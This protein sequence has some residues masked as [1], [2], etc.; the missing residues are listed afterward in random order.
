MYSSAEKCAQNVIIHWAVRRRRVLAIV[1]VVAALVPTA[2]AY[3]G[4]GVNRY[5]AFGV[6]GDGTIAAATPSAPA[7]AITYN[8][9]LAPVG[10][11]LTAN[12]TPSGDS[13]TADLSVSGLAP[14]RG[15]SVIA[16]VNTCGGV[17]GGEG[18]RFQKHIDPAATPG[19]PSANP[20]YSNP[21]NE[22]WL[23]VHTD[24]TGAPTSHTTVPFVLTDRGP[25]SMVVHDEQQTTATSSQPA[26][27]TSDRVACLTL[28]ATPYGDWE[29][30]QVSRRRQI[31]VG[32][33]NRNLCG[34]GTEV[35]PAASCV[36]LQLDLGVPPHIV[37]RIVGHAMLDLTMGIYAHAALDEQRQALRMLE[38]RLSGW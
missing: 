2:C 9:T 4:L 32:S 36:T 19:K 5:A 17:P 27:E 24:S 21:S 11:H 10:G 23:D 31:V 20:E 35:S 3:Q 33:L 12:L 13:T 16:H 7:A 34:S 8:T 28:T 22:I 29:L 37:M 14:N 18:P 38:D 26:G 25:G 15:F 30:R 6:R 1:A